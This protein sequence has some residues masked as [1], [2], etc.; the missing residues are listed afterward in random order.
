MKVFHAEE[1]AAAPVYDAQQ[2]L[3]D[4]H[5]RARGTWVAIDDPDLGPMTVQA[6]LAFLSDTP[7]RVDHLGR[8]LGAHNEKIFG[9]L[10]G[11]DGERLAELRM[12][13][14]I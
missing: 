9:E 3:A 7:G 13:G 8:A 1:V 6:P 4:E 5:L 12:A 2:L 14:T 10:L 11:I